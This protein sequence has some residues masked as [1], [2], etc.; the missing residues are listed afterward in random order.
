MAL[1][2]KEVKKIADVEAGKAVKGHEGR[3]HKG[4]AKM[5]KGGMTN[6]NMLKLG[7]NNAKIK[8]QFGK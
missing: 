1:G 2:K 5:A 7:R 3:M 6:E 8:N 4:V